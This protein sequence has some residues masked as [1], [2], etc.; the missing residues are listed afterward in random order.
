MDNQFYIDEYIDSRGLSEV[1]RV[2]LKWVFNHYSKFQN[3][4]LQELLD[5]ADREE[6]QGIRW[7]KRTLKKRLINYMNYLKK[8][9]LLSHSLHIDIATLCV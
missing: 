3:M 5:E 7:K 2:K 6:E 4:S 9:M 1:T 8:K